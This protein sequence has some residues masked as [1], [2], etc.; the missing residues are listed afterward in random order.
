VVVPGLRKRV[1]WREVRRPLLA[2]AG[3]GVLL[4]L[5]PTVDAVRHRGGNLRSLLDFWT[6]THG[7]VAGWSRAARIVVSQFAVDAPWIS[8]REQRNPFTSGVDP[9]WRLPVVAVA[10]VVAI[11]VARRRGDTATV[12]LG[13]VTAGMTVVAWVSVVRIVDEPY[14][15]LVRWTFLV[16]AL[17]WLTIGWCLLGLARARA[18]V[19]LSRWVGAVIAVATVAIVVA[20]TATV[21][22]TRP[23]PEGDQRVFAALAPHLLHAATRLPAPIVVESS[24][25]LFSAGLAGSVL[26]VLEDAGVDA[27]FPREQAWELGASHAVDSARAGSRLLVAVGA[28]V[29]PLRTDPRYR[30]V[31][32][33]DELTPVERAELERLRPP[34]DD[35]FAQAAWARRHPRLARRADELRRHS[36]RAVVVVTR[37]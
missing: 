15:Y 35:L 12:R 2:S 37:S 28:A 4:W 9:S 21:P 7:H 26:A 17:S 13:L 23:V 11:V 30:V 24:P 14:D 19:Q 16:G 29:E 36:E 31:A 10:L 1:A 5:P 22:D 32:S 34:T 33:Y 18:S 20:L 6:S 8:G 27:R 25:D 3:L